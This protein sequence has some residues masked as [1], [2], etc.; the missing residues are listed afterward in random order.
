MPRYLCSMAQQFIS[1]VLRHALAEYRGATQAQI[2]RQTGIDPASL[3]RFHSGERGLSL[4]NADHLAAYL[5]LRL[6][7]S[8]PRRTKQ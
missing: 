1:D 8:K 4:R 5:G 7:P 2:S 6:T 3:C